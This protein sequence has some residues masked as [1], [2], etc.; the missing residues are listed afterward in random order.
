M[1]EVLIKGVG[2]KISITNN[3]IIINKII[4]KNLE[5]LL[6]NISN[7]SYVKGSMDKNGVI[8]IEWTDSNGK[9]S[10][11]NIMFR[12]FSNDIVEESVNG[13]LNYLNN[14]RE[15]L[16]INHMEKIGFLQQL[17]RESDE[18]IEN[19]N[20]DKLIEQERIANLDKQRIPYCPKCH[21]TSLTYV[22]KKL[23]IGRAVVGGAIAGPTGA[24][25]GGLSSKKGKVKCLNC[26]HTWKL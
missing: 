15:P 24:V 17:N 26:G 11:E 14:P 8:H 7:I 9:K 23:S 21:S 22:D 19:K 16:A 12:C 2:K 6:E 20:K 4:G 25:L 3:S 1:E 13:I 10:K 18:R 5:I